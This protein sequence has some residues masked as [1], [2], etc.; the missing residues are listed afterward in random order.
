MH[1]KNL[2]L[3]S[4]HITEDDYSYK[5]T[6]QLSGNGVFLDLDLVDLETPAKLEEIKKLFGLEEPNKEIRETIFD[7]VMEKAAIS[8]RINEGKDYQEKNAGGKTEKSVKS[9]DAI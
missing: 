5:G 4:L 9:L 3:S 1:I 2:E 6:F 7:M 8:S